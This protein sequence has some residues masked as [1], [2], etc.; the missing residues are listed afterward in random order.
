MIVKPYHPKK[1]LTN[2]GCAHK[3]DDIFLSRTSSTENLIAN[4]IK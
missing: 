1:P 4:E 3:F 2:E